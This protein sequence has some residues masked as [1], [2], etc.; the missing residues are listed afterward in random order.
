MSRFS[1][2]ILLALSLGSTLSSWVLIPAFI[3]NGLF[4]IG[5]FIKYN[6][7]KLVGVYTSVY[8]K[9]ACGIMNTILHQSKSTLVILFMSTCVLIFCDHFVLAFLS[10]CAIVTHYKITKQLWLYNNERE[11]T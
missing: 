8:E 2:W 1:A 6:S 5:I 7:E 11:T 4:S 10:I 9:H 3:L